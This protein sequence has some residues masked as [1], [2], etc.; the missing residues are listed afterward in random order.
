MH[1][2]LAGQPQ[3]VT[4]ALWLVEEGGLDA[5]LAQAVWA[6]LRRPRGNLVAQSLAAHGGSY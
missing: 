6:G 5:E 3:Q 4:G 1:F 2:W